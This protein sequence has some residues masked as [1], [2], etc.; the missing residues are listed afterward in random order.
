MIYTY[1]CA[2]C[3]EEVTL[4]RKMAEYHDDWVCANCGK[5]NIGKTTKR[6]DS[7]PITGKKQKGRYNSEDT[8]FVSK[9]VADNLKSV[10]KNLK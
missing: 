6:I 7:V 3:G 10:K 2:N 4:E 8:G 5:E 1:V 9:A